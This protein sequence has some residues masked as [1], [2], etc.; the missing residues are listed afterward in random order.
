MHKLKYLLGMS[1]VNDEIIKSIK[2]RNKTLGL[3]KIN[4]GN[5]NAWEKMHRKEIRKEENSNFLLNLQS[6]WVL[7]CFLHFLKLFIINK[8]TLKVKGFT[9]F[10]ILISFKVCK[11]GIV[12][13]KKRRGFKNVK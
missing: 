7:S 8:S 2:P 11:W 5:K 10:G 13:N 9:C 1:M 6:F 12:K 4:Y 3:T